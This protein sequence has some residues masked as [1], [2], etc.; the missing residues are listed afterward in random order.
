[1]FAPAE[2]VGRL[3]LMKTSSQFTQIHSFRIRISIQD[4][5]QLPWYVH[6]R[7]T[8]VGLIGGGRV[9]RIIFMCIFH[10]CFIWVF[11]SIQIYSISSLMFEVLFVS[12][13]IKLVALFTTHNIL[14][15]DGRFGNYGKSTRPEGFNAKTYCFITSASWKPC[16]K[17]WLGF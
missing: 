17:M 11:W 7:F 16:M 4:R 6:D 2:A 8:Q 5:S 12:D 14:I 3:F 1:M 10:S 13:K 9:N 15:S